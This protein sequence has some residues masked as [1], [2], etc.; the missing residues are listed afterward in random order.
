MLTFDAIR[1]NP[2]T[3][4]TDALPTPCR[5]LLH[6][7]AYLAADYCCKSEYLLMNAAFDGKYVPAGW[8]RCPGST[9][10]HEIHEAR[11]WS[12]E[13]KRSEIRTLYEKAYGKLTVRPLYTGDSAEFIIRHLFD[14]DC[15]EFRN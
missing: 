6:A 15:G 12:A 9:D 8:R 5:P 2:W 11:G 7:L 13:A 3:V 10:A 1:I 14:E 4:V